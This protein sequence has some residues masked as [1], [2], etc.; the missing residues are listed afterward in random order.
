MLK[1]ITITNFAIIDALT[2]SFE[3]GMSVLT[4]ETGAGKSIII[5]ALALLC[6]G[7]GSSDMIRH[8]QEK[9]VLQGLFDISNSPQAK[10]VLQEHSIPFSEDDILI[11]REIHRTGKTVVRLNGMLATVGLLKELGGQLI[12][13]HGQHEHQHLMDSKNH[14]NLLDAFADEHISD[15]KRE[16]KLAYQN[17]VDARKRVKHLLVSDQQDAQRVVLLKRHVEDIGTVNPIENE[18]ALL[19]KELEELERFKRESQVFE[20]VD[21]L[22]SHEE[23]GVKVSLSRV[24]RELEQLAQKDEVYRELSKD[25]DSSVEKI[26]HVSLQLAEN[27]EKNEFDSQRYAQV[28]ERLDRL[29]KLKDNYGQTLTDVIRYYEISKIELDQLLNK[30]KHLAQAQKDF[31][32][33][34]ERVL[35]VGELLSQSRK[36]A[37][38]Q[39]KN[40][41]QSQLQDLYMD[42]VQ[43]EVVFSR[44]DEKVKV[45]ATGLE[46]VNFL[47]STN[48]GEPLKPLDKV[49]S[50]GEL[51]RIM[52]A[53]KSIFVET[54]GIA[55]IVF[56]EIDTGVSGRVAQA[57]A[58]KM[59]L[60]AKS[61]QVLCISHLPQVAAVAHTHYFVRKK[62]SGDRT[63][64]KLSVLNRKERQEEIA[65]MMTG[66]VVSDSALAHAKSLLE[67][68]E[69]S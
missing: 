47:M 41:I 32:L 17:Y 48:I 26:Q 34:R 16:Y 13:I 11:Q 28:Q 62:I 52:L 42:K 18:E 50:G 51:S 37:A 38:T 45:T 68:S 4:G 53:L 58:N 49:A 61:A 21:S 6:G 19:V 1:E 14:L 66:E 5:D 40:A 20:V 22:L 54:Q 46:D 3:S 60:V 69:R 65:K 23:I 9:A 15:V 30:D 55:T 29:E 64:T 35:Q 10:A 12:D 67:Q 25:I 43:F 31:L 56:D 27:I 57:I 36:V 24:L 8:G 2:A 7:R 59:A 39:L 33:A 63:V 44:Q